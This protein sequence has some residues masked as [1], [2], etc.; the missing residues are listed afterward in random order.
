[1]AATDGPHPPQRPPGPP[2]RDPTVSPVGESIFPKLIR[3][4][5]LLYLLYR[6]VVS[7]VSS[8]GVDSI[9]G[10]H[11]S[12]VFL[13]LLSPKSTIPHRTDFCRGT[14]IKQTVPLSGG[15]PAERAEGGRTSA[16]PSVDRT[17]PPFPRSYLFQKNRAIPRPMSE[18][19]N[20]RARTRPPG[21]DAQG[22]RHRLASIPGP[23]SQR[24]PAL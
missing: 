19:G 13:L 21:L 5:A 15:E 8:N 24:T 9:K 4:M 6:L 12:Q 22:V 23:S 18:S 10:L 7:V 2:R 11:L 17:R 20:P 1:V 14:P 3:I 16:P